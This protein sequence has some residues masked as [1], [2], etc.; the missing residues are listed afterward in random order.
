MIPRAFITEW[1]H[2]APWQRDVQIEQDLVISR[3][4]VELFNDTT[5]MRELLFRGGTALHKLYFDSPTRYSEDLDFVQKNAG[6]IGP[7]VKSIQGLLDGWLK[8]SGTESRRDGFRIYYSFIAE[9]DPNQT[10]KVKIEINTREHFSV[11]PEEDISFRVKSRWYE[12]FTAIKTYH[13]DELAATKL[14]ALYQRKK[15]RDLFDLAQ[16][17]QNH[18]IDNAR[19][20]KA[21]KEYLDHQGVATSKVQFQR[22]LEEKLNDDVFTHDTDIIIL[23]PISYDPHKAGEMVMQLIDL[24]D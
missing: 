5:L 24:L 4:L 15:G 12:G 2:F 3:I 14:R 8:R 9:S 13:I 7:I 16:L 1:Q 21:F 20:I 22:N 11:Y 23:P 18:L 10:S 17:I 6:P 19:V